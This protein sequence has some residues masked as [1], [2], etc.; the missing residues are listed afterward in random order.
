MYFFLITNTSNLHINED[1]CSLSVHGATGKEKSF[2]GG[3]RKESIV[4]K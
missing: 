3:L 2:P 4:L 1:I